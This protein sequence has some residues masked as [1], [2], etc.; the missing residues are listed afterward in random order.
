[1]K[2][3]KTLLRIVKTWDIN[4]KPEYRGFRCADCQKQIRKAWYHWLTT[5]G[6]K[7]PVHFC[8]KCEKKFRLNKIK[9]KKLMVKVNKSKFIKFPGN[10]KSKLQRVVRKC[11]NK[12]KPIYKTFTCDNCGM[13]MF[14]AYHI[15]FILKKNL[16]EVH[17]CRKCGEKTGIGSLLSL[18]D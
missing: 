1:M 2:N 6:Y 9:I 11:N 4:P 18:Q 3:Q 14:K 16:V 12:S 8:A 13:N 10:I 5:T 17:F 15:W 7:T